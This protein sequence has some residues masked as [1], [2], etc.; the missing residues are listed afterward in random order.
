MYENS[1]HDSTALPYVAAT[2]PR[3]SSKRSS[4]AALLLGGAAALALGSFLPWE[5][6]TA[7]LF[8]TITANGMQAGGLFTLASAALILALAWRVGR[9]HLSRRAAFGIFAAAGVALLTVIVKFAVVMSDT[10]KAR[11]VAAVSAG[12]GLYICAAAV[13]VIAV[14]GARQYR[15]RA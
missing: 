12:S 8:G 10:A 9:E 3:P 7:P 13:L 5:T 15:R 11:G 2:A 6:V 4:D 14:G 1:P